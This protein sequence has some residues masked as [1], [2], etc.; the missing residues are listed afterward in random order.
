M[1]HVLAV[2]ASGAA[3]AQLRRAR[4]ARPGAAVAHVLAALVSGAAVAHVLAVL[5]S[6][7]AVAQ[8]W[9]ARRARPGAA[10]AHVLAV[11]ASGAAVAHVLAVLASGA[12]VAH[13]LAALA[14]GAAVGLVLAALASGAAVGLVLAVRASGAA[15]GLVLAVEAELGGGPRARRAR[16]RRRG[17]PRAR[18]RGGGCTTTTPDA[19]HELGPGPRTFVACHSI[20]DICTHCLRA[21]N[22]SPVPMPSGVMHDQ[23]AKS[24]QAIVGSNTADS[25]VLQL[26][27][28]ST[29]DLD[30]TLGELMAKCAAVCFDSQGHAIG[31]EMLVLGK[32][33]SRLK[34]FWQPVSPAMARSYRLD[35]WVTDQ[36]AC[37]V[38]IMVVQ[39]LT[40]YKV[41][42]QSVR[43]TGFD[44]WLGRKGKLPFDRKARL[45]VSGL[46]RG[47]DTDV[48]ARRDDKMNQTKQSD[49]T[50][51]KALIVIVEFG[52][53]ISHVTVKVV[54]RRK[55]TISARSR[56][57]KV[58]P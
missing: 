48:R 30:P 41:V 51:L 50:G 12:A 15:V 52:R 54:P 47:N 23:C 2:L 3:V 49:N 27:A 5:A 40:T 20:M 53:A 37:G 28:G 56:A 32:L 10:V 18:R 21:I 39:S 33:K 34:V 9:R 1:A 17:G 8:L 6:G 57:T 26:L 45:E 11:L 29:P 14:S 13:V 58:K 31:K 42:E 16:L 55:R 44:F 35:T 46:R 19:W 24:F 25:I 36:G 22:V 4:R 7:A 43:G 38:A